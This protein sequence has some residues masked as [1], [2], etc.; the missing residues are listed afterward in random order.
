MQEIDRAIEQFAADSRGASLQTSGR[1]ALR[2]KIQKAATK[3]AGLRA[4]YEKLI[5]QIPAI[6][7]ITSLTDFSRK[8]F[9]SSQV[10]TLLG[11]SQQEYLEDPDLWRN[12]LHPADRPRVLAT[13]ARSSSANQAFTAEYRMLRRDQQLVWFRDEAHFVCDQFGKA[14]CLQGVMLDITQYKLT[15]EA[16]R[17]SEEKF[18]T[19]FESAK[20]CIFIKDPEL[21]YVL[22]NPCVEKVLQLPADQIVGRMDD[23]LFGSGFGATTREIDQQ[24]LA[25]K[26]IETEYTVPIK[27][28]GKTF[29]VIKVPLRDRNG[30]IT[31]LCGISRDI[32]ER[33]Q[34]EQELR[35]RE[36][37]LQAQTRRLE[38]MNT[39]LKVLLE[40]R[41]EDRA[42]LE[43]NVIANAN[44]RLLPL[45]DKLK[46]TRLSP[47]QKTYVEALETSTREIVSPFV[48]KI[49]S[50]CARLSS[51]EFEVALLIKEGKSS[52][53]IAELLHIDD[54]TVLFHRQ[55]IRKKLGLRNKKIN[56]QSYLRTLDT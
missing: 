31:G 14:L 32:T 6:I 47:E 1:E 46:R 23:D 26:I 19:L 7:Y 4:R 43:A 55:N 3:I 25:G 54:Y 15:E 38:E 20:D 30:N 8:T 29:A 28:N 18:R 11:Y 9:I 35:N 34:T 2:H 22:V 12:S 44:E 17:E 21:N 33:K 50:A 56:I 13:L 53:E 48:R 16:L 41:Q 5:N 51:R 52:K 10:K 42:E 45:L 27:G 40:K 49:T 36:S 39:T 37:K 24:V